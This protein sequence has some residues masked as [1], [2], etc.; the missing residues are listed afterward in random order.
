MQLA[1]NGLHEY[2]T[3]SSNCIRRRV[4]FEKYVDCHDVSLLG[5]LVQRRVTH[6]HQNTLVNITPLQKQSRSKTRRQCLPT[7]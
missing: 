1:N 4:V 5:S 6:L 2:V 7:Q 3:Y